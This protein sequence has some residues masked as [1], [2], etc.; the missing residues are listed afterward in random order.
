M[1]GALGPGGFEAAVNGQD[2]ARQP[3]AIHSPRYVILQII[4]TR[5]D[6]LS[7]QLKF[8]QFQS[9]VCPNHCIFFS[10]D[11]IEPLRAGQRTLMRETFDLGQPT[12]LTRMHTAVETEAQAQL[13]LPH[14]PRSELSDPGGDFYGLPF[15]LICLQIV[16][17][18]KT[19][20]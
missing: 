13:P 3:Q 2:D 14:T 12:P 1:S 17:I 8:A 16:P 19:M 7:C 6:K 20:F 15:V 4:R 10:A 5:I 18:F 11:E 9:S